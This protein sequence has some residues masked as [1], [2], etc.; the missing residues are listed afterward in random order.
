MALGK[1]TE[2]TGG[3]TETR[4]GRNAVPPFLWILD[5]FELSFTAVFSNLA[6]QGEASGVVEISFQI[7]TGCRWLVEMARWLKRKGLCALLLTGQGVTVWSVYAKS[8]NSRCMLLRDV[9]TAALYFREA[10]EILSLVC[11]HGIVNCFPNSTTGDSF[12]HSNVSVH[13]S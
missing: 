2:I 12:A 10:R 4:K 5:V 1:D 6:D 7:G 3:F 13:I 8:K 11:H 9:V